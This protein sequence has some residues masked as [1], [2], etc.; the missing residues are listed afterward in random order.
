DGRLAAAFNLVKRGITNLCVCGGDGSL[1]GANIFRSE[2][3]GLLAEL[4]Q[5]GRITDT[6]AKQH[7]HLNIVGLVGSIDNDFC[8]TDMTIGADSA[9]HRIMEIRDLHSSSDSY[10]GQPH[11]SF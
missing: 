9:L 11:G 7:N 2:W 8:G 6:L 1:T 10:L 5:K 4:V 3:S